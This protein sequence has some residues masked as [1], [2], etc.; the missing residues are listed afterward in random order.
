MP[1]ALRTLHKNPSSS[2]RQLGHPVGQARPLGACH[3]VKVQHT[4]RH[5]D[6]APSITP[7][8]AQRLLLEQS[9]PGT[10][11]PCPCLPMIWNVL[12]GLIEYSSRVRLSEFSRSSAPLHVSCVAGGR[13]PSLSVPQSP[14]LQD[15]GNDDDL[16]CGSSCAHCS[17]PPHPGS[18]SPSCLWTA[19]LLSNPSA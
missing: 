19:W 17:P 8:S 5:S 7:A 1:S 12:I 6:L 14:C 10:P 18:Y 2:G 13:F 11:V 9:P 15:V 4:Y 16:G 3:L